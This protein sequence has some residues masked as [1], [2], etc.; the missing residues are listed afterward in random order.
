MRILVVLA[1]FLSL[2]GCAY[3]GAALGVAEGKLAE[4][5]EQR[6]RLSDAEA[7][8]VR[9]AVCLMNVGGYWRTL[10]PRERQAVDVLCGG[11]TGKQLTADGEN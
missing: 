5:V 3:S 4:F 2:G 6:Q 1:L 9:Q 7:K 10:S 11:D 8:A